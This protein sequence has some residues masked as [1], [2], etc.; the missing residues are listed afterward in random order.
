M[1]SLPGELHPAREALALGAG[2]GG[3]SLAPVAL[4]GS[5]TAGQSSCH[6][7]PHAALG[8]LPQRLS[9]RQPYS[10]S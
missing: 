6:L 7:S 1:V 9:E 2:T 4:P 5:R 8:V 10:S 3:G